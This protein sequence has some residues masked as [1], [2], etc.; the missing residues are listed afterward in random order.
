MD[1]VGKGV[2]PARLH[3]IPELCKMNSLASTTLAFSRTTTPAGNIQKN[4]SLIQGPCGVVVPFGAERCLFTNR[5]WS[6]LIQRSF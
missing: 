1:E 4:L 6:A 2:L 3:L 5:S